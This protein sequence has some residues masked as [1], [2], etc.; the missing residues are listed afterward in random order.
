MNT[1]PIID[2][3]T[4]TNFLHTLL[5]TKTTKRT[6]KRTAASQSVTLSRMIRGRQYETDGI[7]V[8][9][10]AGGVGVLMFVP[11][12][13]GSRLEVRADDGR[14]SATV[15]VRH[16]TEMPSGWLVGQQ[17]VKR[18]GKWLID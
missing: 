13:I 14:L 15:I 8:N 12:S 9:I 4:A 1:K 17:I 3:Q 16:C 11:V 10:S 2:R 18:H 6:T 5:N 7:V